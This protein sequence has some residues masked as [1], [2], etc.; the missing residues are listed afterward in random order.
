VL[1]ELRAKVGRPTSEPAAGEEG[2]Y[3][4]VTMPDN[5]GPVTYEAL[6]MS[7]R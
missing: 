7:R 4:S 6:Q 1:T 5:S 3:E 2:N